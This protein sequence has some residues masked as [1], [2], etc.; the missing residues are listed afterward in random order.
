[1]ELRESLNLRTIGAYCFSYCDKLQ[2]ITLPAGELGITSLGEWAFYECSQL[3]SFDT[4]NQL[5]SLTWN[6]F[7]GCDSLTAVTLGSQMDTV[8]DFEDYVNA[9]L[10]QIHLHSRMDMERE[11]SAYPTTWSLQHVRNLNGTYLYAHGD[12]IYDYYNLRLTTDAYNGK[13]IKFEMS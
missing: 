2:T 10:S 4:G 12:E 3:T 11:V 5:S 7:A 1:M 6:A 8:Y 13:L 9:S